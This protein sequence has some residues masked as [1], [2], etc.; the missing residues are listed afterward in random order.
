MKDSNILRI[1]PNQE[2]PKLPLK[3]DQMPLKLDENVQ[4]MEESKDQQIWMSKPE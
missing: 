3:R 1:L 4:A 2:R